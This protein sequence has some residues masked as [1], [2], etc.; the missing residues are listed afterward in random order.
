MIAVF[1]QY[2]QF[3]WI[4]LIFWKFQCSFFV[5]DTK[6]IF[7]IIKY[8]NSDS[9]TL[10]IPSLERDNEKMK[11]IYYYSLNV[12]NPWENIF[13]IPGE[14]ISKIQF[15]TNFNILL[16]VYGIRYRELDDK[17]N[18]DTMLWRLIVSKL[19]CCTNKD[20]EN[21]SKTI[22]PDQNEKNFV[23]EAVQD[24]GKMDH[25]KK[26]VI[27]LDSQFGAVAGYDTKKN[28]WDIGIQ[29]ER[30]KNS[31]YSNY[32]INMTAISPSILLLFT[33]MGANM[34][35]ANDDDDDPFFLLYPRWTVHLA[36]ANQREI[37]NLNRLWNDPVKDKNKLPPGMMQTLLGKGTERDFGAS[38]IVCFPYFETIE[39][40]DKFS[41]LK[42]VTTNTIKAGNDCDII[43]NQE[44]R[45]GKALSFQDVSNAYKNLYGKT[46]EQVYQFHGAI[47]NN[48]E[49]H[50]LVAFAILVYDTN[51]FFDCFRNPEKNLYHIFDYLR[52]RVSMM[53]F[54]NDDKQSFC[55]GHGSTVNATFHRVRILFQFLTGGIAHAHV[56]GNCRL[57]ALAYTWMGV[58][59]PKNENELVP[60]CKMN[61][62]C[63]PLFDICTSPV[64]LILVNN[65]GKLPGQRIE[66][67]ELKDIRQI[68]QE[69][70]AGY[71][72]ANEASIQTV[73]MKLLKD[74]IPEPEFFDYMKSFVKESAQ[75][76][77][78]A[79][80]F[81]QLKIDI[82][83][84]SVKMRD[85]VAEKLLKETQSDIKKAISI[86]P[87]DLKRKYKIESRLV[88]H[89]KTILD[90]IMK[91]FV[92]CLYID[93]TEGGDYNDDP[94]EVITLLLANNGKTFSR[95]YLNVRTSTNCIK[96]PISDK[97]P[98]KT[99]T[100]Y[101]NI[102]DSVNTAMN[103]KDLKKSILTC[104]TSGM[105]DINEYPELW[106]SLKKSMDTGNK[107]LFT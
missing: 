65:A 80:E 57:T 24:F 86:A 103:K 16:A 9:V 10:E 6:T 37:D 104:S 50:S 87:S 71:A 42:E 18:D 26:Q 88:S 56:D 13:G 99:M 34:V 31:K 95:F 1:I 105:N 51:R 40:V 49:I 54:G 28:F 38:P 78:T 3:Q 4:F 61:I 64:Q 77:K 97:G 44:S 107:N 90:I 5:L 82:Q 81:K 76:A 85:Y 7:F 84:Q 68:S 32:K 73:V 93:K 53:L 63:K 102:W 67:G 29:T 45:I 25:T 23:K 43:Y 69:W 41:Y 20:T 46:M 30:E 27:N 106:V 55:F 33:R 91:F 79:P 94:L 74:K 59:P 12:Q 19:L 8:R 48:P 75:K 92:E 66:K 98:S 101:D 62:A 47:Q 22:I 14:I 17:I 35:D 15:V 83:T 39:Q 11:Q 60:D 100:D 58:K 70:Q 36:G 21:Y 2:F 72:A 89:T 52:G 96:F